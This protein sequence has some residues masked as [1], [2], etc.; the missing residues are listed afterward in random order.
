MDKIYINQSLVKDLV[1]YQN[2]KLCGLVF[3]NKWILQQ[4]GEGSR[5][6]KLGHYFEYLCTGALGKGESEPQKPEYTKKGDLAT[7]FELAKKQSIFFQELMEKY[8][9]KLIS[10]GDKV[11][12]D[13]KWIGTLLLRLLRQIIY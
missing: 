7:D 9:I 13:E 5:A 2:D 6:N 12:A 3:T 11:L 10:A 8:Q 1:K 4:F